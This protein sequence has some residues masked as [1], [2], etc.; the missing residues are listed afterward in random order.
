VL[1]QYAHVFLFLVMGALFPLITL[2][3]AS[4]VRFSSRDKIQTIP[5]ECG[6]A[7]IGSAYVP[8]NIRFYLFA[9]IFILFDVESLYLLPW[10]L[11]FKSQGLTGI[12]EMGIF[13]AVL[14]LGLVYVW[15]RGALRWGI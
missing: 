15:K 3:F 7:P 5:Y 8:I 9:L 1:A 14:M 4:L 11:V 12:I 13:M 2:G 10:A 6:Y